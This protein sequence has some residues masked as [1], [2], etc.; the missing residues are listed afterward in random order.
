M[1]TNNSDEG[2]PPQ[3]VR[4]DCSNTSCVGFGLI[5][6]QLVMCPFCGAQLRADYSTVSN[7]TLLRTVREAPAS[8]AN[9]MFQ[10]LSA[11]SSFKRLHFVSDT[12]MAGMRLAGCLLIKHYQGSGNIVDV[13]EERIDKMTTSETHGAW[14]NLME[15]LYDYLRDSGPG[16]LLEHY[17]PLLG[18]LSGGKRS[19]RSVAVENTFTDEYGRRQIVRSE[20]TA[21]QILVNFRNRYLG[22]GTVIT[23]QESRDILTTYLPVF[24][25]FLDQLCFLNEFRWSTDAGASYVGVQRALSPFRRLI[26]Y[27][28]SDAVL[29]EIASHLH[30]NV[31]PGRAKGNYRCN[32]PKCLLHTHGIGLPTAQ[33]CPSCRRPLAVDEAR[34]MDEHDALIVREYP[35]V[36]AL[37]YQRAILEQDVYRK[38]HLLAES[39]LNLLKYL[40]LLVASEYFYSGHK[41][42]GINAN[43]RELL[44]RP[45]MGYWNRF[46]RES[47]EQLDGIGHAWFMPELPEY[48]RTIENSLFARDPHTPTP[49]GK[50]IE[51]RNRHLGHGMV[52]ADDLCEELWQTHALLLKELLLKLDFC[53]RYTMVSYDKLQMWRLMGTEIVPLPGRGPTREQAR[54]Q[55]VNTTGDA[56]N[57]VPFFVLPGEY[58]REG[59]SSRARLMIYEQ[60]TGKRIVFFSPESVVDETSGG[61]LRCLQEMLMAKER[62][63]P[64]TVSTLS[65]AGLVGNIARRNAEVRRGLSNERKVLDGVYQAR[66]EAEA[67]LQAWVGAPSSLFFVAAEAGSGKT[68][69]LVE[70]SRQYSDLGLDSLLVRANRMASDDLGVE[71][72]RQLNLEDGFSLEDSDA[73]RK[74]SQEH[75]L[76]ILIDGGNEH[77]QPSEF[78]RSVMRFLAE[79]HGGR[80]KC[81]ITWRA[82]S[83]GELPVVEKCHEPLVFADNLDAGDAN[84]IAR[85]CHWLKPLNRIELEGAWVAHAAAMPKTH[86]P[87][88]TPDELG[89]EDPTLL[90][91]LQNP[92]ILRIF[93]GLF[94]GKRLPK[95]S[96]FIN[97]W[98]LFHERLNA[99]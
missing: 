35:Y 26:V 47:I 53:R 49:I 25:R 39:F 94:H 37:P 10:F 17:Q 9:P 41:H 1:R 32:T 70:M 81:V 19:E 64:L 75:P 33:L 56:M 97:I 40:G 43:F 29:A 80:I 88:F 3:L 58:F 16:A 22:H 90:G 68:N 67:A 61:A 93:L 55:L 91:Q 99:S 54:V 52:P 12:M 98:S 21:M 65:S 44:F 83:K 24:T 60:N 89:Q 11:P 8:M 92:L 13:I 69:L 59:T 79:Y 34:M 7:Q 20:G 76:L 82:N 15:L 73:F 45:Q 84:I 38:L 62:E 48:Y 30:T 28:S 27:D 66:A 42:K 5:Y 71:F 72:R 95:Q 23:E 78:L 63:A 31:L 87:L 51:L 46:I 50:L 4:S 14:P 77:P 96:G 86:K 57:L 74:Y 6:E 18:K 85:Y 2:L 36:L